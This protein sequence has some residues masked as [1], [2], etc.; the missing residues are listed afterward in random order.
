MRPASIALFAVMAMALPAVAHAQPADLPIP[1]ATSTQLPPGVAVRGSGKDAVYVDAEGRTLYGLDMRTVH[2]WSPN[3]ALHCASHCDPEW[4]PVLAPGERANIDFPPGFGDALR[5]SIETGEA[6]QRRRDMP[7]TITREDGSTFFLNP[8]SAPDWTVIDGPQGPQW[9]YM[10]WHLVFRRTDEAPGS[11]AF[12]GA[13]GF[14]WNTLKFVPP[15]PEIA[16]PP[17][18]ASAFVDGAY[19]LTDDHGRV[20]Y[21]GACSTDCNAWVPLAA[22]MANRGIGEWLVDRQQETPRWTW[23]GKPVFVAASEDPST[24][25]TGATLLRPTAGGAR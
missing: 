17:Q 4:E 7:D 9:V 6:S 11:T 13:E 20:L 14:T 23:R 1:A 24:L 3:P 22:G 16:A 2:R 10:G 18:V 25:P 21:T 8:Q 15:A 19:A 5:K 12:D